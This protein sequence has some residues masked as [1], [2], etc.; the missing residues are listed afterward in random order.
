[1]ISPTLSVKAFFASDKG[2]ATCLLSMFVATTGYVAA[3]V[4]N[5]PANDAPTNSHGAYVLRD[6]D[7]EQATLSSNA[8]I[9]M[10][11][12]GSILP[13]IGRITA[14]EVRNGHWTVETSHGVIIRQ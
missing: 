12:I 6:A 7:G 5:S 2:L 3:F 9:Q 4:I 14:I 13:G 10:V 11:R 1:M 8:Q